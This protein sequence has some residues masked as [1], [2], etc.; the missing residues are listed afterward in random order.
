LDWWQ[1][2][3]VHANDQGSHLNG[4]VFT[5]SHLTNGTEGS[6]GP[7]PALK[8]A[9]LAKRSILSD[10]AAANGSAGQ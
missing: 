4:R 2:Y 5:R 3:L 1:F 10:K 9:L 8:I 6:A 7:I